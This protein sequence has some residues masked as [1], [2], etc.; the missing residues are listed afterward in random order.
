MSRVVTTLAIYAVLTLRQNTPAELA[1]FACK[2]ALTGE[3]V[4]TPLSLLGLME[5]AQSPWSYDQFFV[6]F[7]L[8]G[9]AVSAATGAFFLGPE[10][11]R[12]GKLMPTRPP[13]DPEVQRRIRPILLL[14][15]LDV[16]LLLAIVFVMTAKPFL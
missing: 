4:Y 12:L 1:S 2:A 5:N 14:V 7:A 16:V 13:E 6:I 3:R 8:V 10:A 11:A 15:R 9:W